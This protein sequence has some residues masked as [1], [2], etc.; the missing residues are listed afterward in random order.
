MGE[1]LRHFA[2]NISLVCEEAK[3]VRGV[4]IDRKKEYVLT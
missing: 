1:C 3:E 4:I 2:E